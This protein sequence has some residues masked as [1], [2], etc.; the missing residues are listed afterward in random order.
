[1]GGNDNFC[2]APAGDA[3]IGPISPIG[4]VAK[5]VGQVGHTKTPARI[6]AYRGVVVRCV[7]Y[8]EASFANFS[9]PSTL[10]N[11]QPSQSPPSIAVS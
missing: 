8:A 1:M 11:F 7:R 10:V 4:P 6:Y 2:R 5:A 3:N 9:V